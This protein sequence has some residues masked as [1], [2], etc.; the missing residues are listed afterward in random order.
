MNQEIVN[1]FWNFVG[2]TDA[3]ECWLWTGNLSTHFGQ[4]RMFYKN[5]TLLAY[6]VSYEI[7]HGEIP[8]GLIIRHLCDNPSCVNPEHLTLGTQKDNVH[9]MIERGR[10]KYPPKKSGEHHARAKLNQEQVNEI[11]QSQESGIVLAKKFNVSPACISVIR[12]NK[13]WNT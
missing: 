5:K 10:A 9:D 6:R 7:H 12:N 4:A 2:N 13:K 11:R 8:K 3:N 1:R